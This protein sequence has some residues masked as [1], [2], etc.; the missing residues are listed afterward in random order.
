M[1]TAFPGSFSEGIHT[2]LSRIFTH[3]S[4]SL[5]SSCSKEKRV[6]SPLLFVHESPWVQTSLHM[7]HSR[8][9]R[10]TLGHM[11]DACWD[12]V[13]AFAVT[14][15]VHRITVVWPP[16]HG[17]TSAFCSRLR[18]TALFKHQCRVQPL[19]WLSSACFSDLR[20]S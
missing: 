11:V 19:D 1:N 9:V 13:A 17:S 18:N 14:S 5:E 2:H 3:L 6:G 12:S 7:F 8:L 10:Y 16:Q 15:H 20:F 4:W